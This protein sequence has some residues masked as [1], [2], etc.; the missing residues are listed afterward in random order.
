MPLTISSSG[1]R[2]EGVRGHRC[3]LN[4]SPFLVTFFEQGLFVQ[5]RT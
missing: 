3:F 2:F 4:G 5:N 1:D